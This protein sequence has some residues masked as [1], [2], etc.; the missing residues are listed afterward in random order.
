[1]RA[2][3]CSYTFANENTISFID[4]STE[5]LQVPVGRGKRITYSPGT[6]VLSLP[7]H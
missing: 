1:M 5:L 6:Q 7:I 4:C 3:L 2:L